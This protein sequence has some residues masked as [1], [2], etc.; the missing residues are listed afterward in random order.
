MK[1]KASAVWEGTL[2]ERT[3]SR[4]RRGGRGGS[5]CRPKVL[6]GTADNSPPIHR[7][8][9]SVKETKS[10]QRRKK[11]GAGKERILPSLAGLVPLCG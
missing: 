11:I 7:W 9:T 10:R 6:P 1:R 4:G 3:V 5:G 8:E 2:K